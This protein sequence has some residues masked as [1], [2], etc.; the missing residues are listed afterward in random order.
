MAT[1]APSARTAP[2]KAVIP[3]VLSNDDLRALLGQTEELAKG[4]GGD[5]HRMTLKAGVLQTDDGEMFPPLKGRPSVVLRIVSPPVYY[6]AFFLSE[7]ED[8]GGFDARRLGRGD[9]NGR[10]SRK[11]DD[12][13]AQ[14]ADHNEA[15]ALYDQ[16]EAA[17]GKK[18]NFKA[19]M[20]VQIAPESGEFTGDE[21]EYTLSLSTTSI[22]EWRG[23]SRDPFAGS[24]TDMNFITRLGT[25]ARDNAAA[26]GLDEGGQKKA[27]L[28]ALTA[29]RMGGVVAEV[30]ILMDEN[31]EK[32][33]SWWVL[34]FNPIVI[35]PFEDAPALEAGDTASGDDVP[36]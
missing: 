30:S 33:R 6:N 19:D 16:I 11:Y 23:T 26:A 17:T 13:A 10:F 27:I 15:N 5:Y 9:L 24:V 31:Q 22:F 2:S 18:G 34:S 8:D 14:A 28:D 32:T 3:A 1:R 29:L 35:A 21:T 7:N 25:L 12:P 20:V 4:G 36:F